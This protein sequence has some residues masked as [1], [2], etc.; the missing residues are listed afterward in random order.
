[1]SH[2]IFSAVEGHTAEGRSSE[3]AEGSLVNPSPVLEV[4]QDSQDTS[5]TITCTPPLGLLPQDITTPC[6][7]VLLDT[8]QTQT[9]L[10]CWQLTCQFP[11]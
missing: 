9:Q 3:A 6:P 5:S 7:E 11:T 1:M 8:E 4:E 10:E 2:A